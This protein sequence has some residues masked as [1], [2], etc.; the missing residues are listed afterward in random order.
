M[1]GRR[2]CRVVSNS[3]A[4]SLDRGNVPRAWLIHLGAESARGGIGASHLDTLLGNK[5]GPTLEE[6]LDGYDIPGYHIRR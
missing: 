4:P 1:T 6:L 2:D 5:D 3:I